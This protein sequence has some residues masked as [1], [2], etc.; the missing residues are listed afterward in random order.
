MC[1]SDLL[2]FLTSFCDFLLLEGIFFFSDWWMCC[3]TLE[4]MIGS[5]PVWSA[6]SCGTIGVLFIHLKFYFILQFPCLCNSILEKLV[7]TCSMHFANKS[8]CSQNAIILYFILVITVSAYLCLFVC[9]LSVMS[10]QLNTDLSICSDKVTSSSETFGD[11][12]TLELMDILTQY[13]GRTNG[14]FSYFTWHSI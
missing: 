3:A 10:I 9:V 14:L 12:E 6:R 4:N 5:C 13:L 11:Q 7:S 8:D 1:F 2:L